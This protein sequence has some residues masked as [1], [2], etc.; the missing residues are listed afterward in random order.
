MVPLATRAPV[1]LVAV[2]LS[3][4]MFDEIAWFFPAGTYAAF[5]HDLGLSYAQ[6]SAVLAA[7]ALTPC[8]RFPVPASVPRTCRRHSQR[9]VSAAPP[10]PGNALAPRRSR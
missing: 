8:G 4:R 7:A 10:D 3:L 2:L 6:A 1:G 9:L 5:R